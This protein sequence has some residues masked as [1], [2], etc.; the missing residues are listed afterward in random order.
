MFIL[1]LFSVFSFGEFARTSGFCAAY[2]HVGDHGEHGEYP[3][4]GDHT[5]GILRSLGFCAAYPHVGD[6]GEGDSP[7]NE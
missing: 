3:H 6:H 2:P 7:A 1:L 4:V 5:L